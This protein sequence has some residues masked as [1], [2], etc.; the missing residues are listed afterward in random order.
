MR[1]MTCDTWHVTPDTW[2]LAPD[3]WYMTRDTWHLICFVLY[4]CYYPHTSRDSV[5]GRTDWHWLGNYWRRESRVLRLLIFLYSIPVL[6][7]FVFLKLSLRTN[8]GT[9]TEGWNLSKSMVPLNHLHLHYSPFV[10]PEGQ[11]RMIANTIRWEWLSLALAG[12]PGST[13]FVS[14][15]IWCLL[16]LSLACPGYW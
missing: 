14:A 1:N 9:L 7:V 4:R 16:F 10:E 3:S 11:G 12:P 15:L 13:L 8:L 6:L 5:S 2:H